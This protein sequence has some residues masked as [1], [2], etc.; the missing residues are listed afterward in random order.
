MR[1][2]PPDS[3]SPP[4]PP[5][6]RR[7]F[8]AGLLASPITAGLPSAL[9]RHREP[10][11]AE[12]HLGR[13]A[14]PEATDPSM[15]ELSVVAALTGAGSLAG[16]AFRNGVEMAVQDINGAGGLFGRLLRVATYDTQSSPQGARATAP[17]A[18]EGPPLAVLGPVAAGETMAILPFT[19]ERRVLQ[20]AAAGMPEP[21]DPTLLLTGP[22]LATRMALLAGWLASAPGG[23]SV[24]RLALLTAVGRRHEPGPGAPLLAAAC[25]ARGMEVV[26]AITLPPA[27]PGHGRGGAEIES[28]LAQLLAR[29][30]DALFLAAGGAVAGRL[31]ATLRRQA[32][33][34]LLF[35]RAGL[36]APAALH[37]AG[38]AAIGVRVLE[39]LTPDAPTPPVA[40]FRTRFEALYHI[41]AE[42]EAMQ[43]YIAV[44]MFRA[45]LSRSFATTP[46]P[47]PPAPLPPGVYTGPMLAAALR[48]A[49]LTQADAPGILLDTAWGAAGEPQRTA[50]L[51]EVMPGLTLGW[52][53]VG[54]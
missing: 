15:L 53:P 36:V 21:A 30:P 20:I 50:W 29:A 2:P 11:R 18:L 23:R 40:A 43:G 31:I 52:T 49:P 54:A 6:G 32:P 13:Y 24:R 1:P 44:A 4:A 46:P 3:S 33:E 14:S 8:A 22:S 38:D 5:L 9:P 25:R 28:E 16:D 42:P 26:G 37:A 41:P 51:A 39:A 27:T 35:G 10:R 48:A 17:R 7:A 45:A 19:R 34:L 47:A 12:P